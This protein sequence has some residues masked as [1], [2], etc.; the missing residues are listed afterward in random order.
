MFHYHSSNMAKQQ[1][2]RTM[3]FFLETHPVI[4]RSSYPVP[5]LLDRYPPTTTLISLSGMY[6]LLLYCLIYRLKVE[7][8]DAN[9]MMEARFSPLHS[10]SVYGIEDFW[11]AHVLTSLVFLAVLPMLSPVAWL[12]LRSAHVRSSACRPTAQ[13]HESSRNM[14]DWIQKC[15]LTWDSVSQTNNNDPIMENRF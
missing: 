3:T 1:P 4:L 10:R 9:E 11:H 15:G 7:C 14:W 12:C 13:L 5:K 6:L 8:H 2:L